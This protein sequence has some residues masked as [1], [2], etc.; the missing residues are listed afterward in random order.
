MLPDLQQTMATTLGLSLSA[1]LNDAV[2][3]P[4]ELVKKASIEASAL[5][6]YKDRLSRYGN[7][8]YKNKTVIRLSSLY[9]G[10]YSQLCS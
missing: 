6:Q 2:V 4:E 8:R 9:T 3:T 5:S 7:F 10:N 1:G